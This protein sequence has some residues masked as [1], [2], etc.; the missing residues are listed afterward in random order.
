MKKI[1][2]YFSFLMI[3]SCNCDQGNVNTTETTGYEV[4]F[5]DGKKNTVV[6]QPSQPTQN[7]GGLRKIKGED[8]NG[9]ELDSETR[10]LLSA[11]KDYVEKGGVVP[12]TNPALGNGSNLT[13]LKNKLPVACN[14]IDL[15]WL[16]KEVKSPEDILTSNS[17][18]ANNPNVNAC[19]FKWDNGILP[20]CGIFLQ[21]MENPVPDE[22]ENYATYFIQ[23]KLSGGEMDLN[24]NNYKYEKYDVVGISG[25]YSGEQG[26][27][28]WQISPERLFMLAF[29][30]GQSKKTEK[31]YA[32]AIAKHVMSNYE[33]YL[34]SESK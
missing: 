26:K 4:T 14:L 18:A 23:G 16:E 15:K 2:Y 7:S 33:N 21:I 34:K 11:K 13:A 3:C 25:A 31:G 9:K 24:N 28:F 12:P 8:E 32:D 17:T 6:T 27:F 20:N 1:F 29:N 22:V 30:T 5:P 19:F 10:D